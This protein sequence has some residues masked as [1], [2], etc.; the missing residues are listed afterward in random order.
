MH[1]NTTPPLTKVLFLEMDA[2]QHSLVREWAAAGLMPNVQR[3]LQRGIVGPTMAPEGFFV[4]SIWAS[5]MTGVSPARHG[6]HSWEQLKP[7]T[8]EFFRNITPRYMKRAPFWNALSDAGKRVAIFDIPLSGVSEGLNG[9][10]S[11]EWGAHD[12]NLGFDTWPPQL[13]DEI[14]AKFG[15]APAMSCDG[16][17]TPEQIAA[18]RDGLV[19][20]VEA[21]ADLTSHYLSQGGWDFF[22]QVF[23]ESHCAGHQTWHLAD[24][25]SPHYDAAVAAIAG[26]PM[27]DVYVAIDK[28][29]GR[30]LKLVGDDTVVVFLLGH[31]MGQ[32]YGAYYL[33][34]DILLRLGVAKPVAKQE[35]PAASRASRQV[36]DTALS[37]VWRAM[38]RPVKDSL[39]SVRDGLRDWID[40]KPGYERP[41]GPRHIDAAASPCF[42]IDNNHA[43]S[44][45]RLNLVGREPNGVLNPGTEADAFCAQLSR[46]L[47]AIM[48]IDRNVPAFTA[49]TPV[50]DLYRG[51]HMD[52]LPDLLVQWN[53]A[54]PVGKVR[55]SSPKLGVLEGQYRLSRTGEHQREG[56]FA[57]FG[58]DIEPR[59]L[60]RTVS[61]MDFAP[62]FAGLLGVELK[63]IDGQPIAEVLGRVDA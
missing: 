57:A 20:S 61:V 47:L 56:L 17:K 36:T 41:G 31:G 27:Q 33:F 6:V 13:K 14:L 42:M 32:A 63:D 23:T 44:A 22:A 29:L 25:T 51:E 46:D 52:M 3:L 38:P 19:R 37:A 35:L 11:V 8:Y 59:L 24:P 43:A 9:I 49:V 12:A 60:N 15:P 10:Q 34:P 21:K 4:G 7:G 55:L 62:T 18:F 40:Y 5:L 45:I 30:V 39:R 54:I 48:D 1:S 2:A 28:A 53:P 50:A 58:G 26:N 16:P